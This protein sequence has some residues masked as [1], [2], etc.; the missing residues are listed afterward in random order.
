MIRL[1]R[2]H[3]AKAK[4]L[5][6]Q[7]SDFTAEGSPPPG[8]V[9]VSLPVTADKTTKAASRVPAS[10]PGAHKRPAVGRGR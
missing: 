2:T 8:K 1:P 6:Q 5:A 4:N 9:D 7:N 3:A 10:L